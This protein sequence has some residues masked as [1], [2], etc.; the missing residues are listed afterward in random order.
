VALGLALRG[1]AR[2]AIDV[3]DGLVA[4]LGHICE[5]SSVAAEIEFARVPRS[6]AM[7]KCLPRP[8]ATAALLAGGDDYELCFTAGRDRREALPRL[9]RRVGV[10]LTRIGRIVR[11]RRQGPLVTVLEADGRPVTLK[12]KGFEHFA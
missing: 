3:S 5:R 4:D 7:E 12:H 6:P 8:A 1:V 11:S 2:S 9:S 10:E